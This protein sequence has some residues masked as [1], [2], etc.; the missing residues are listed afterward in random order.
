M[1]DETNLNEK[2]SALLDEAGVESRCGLMLFRYDLLLKRE[3]VDGLLTIPR[4]SF[5]EMRKYAAFLLENSSLSPE[6]K[7]YL[8]GIESGKA[9]HP[10][11]IGE[12]I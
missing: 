7:E 12:G 9:P 4:S 5:D 1:S 6:E 2:I 3:N 10:L 8:E 11:K